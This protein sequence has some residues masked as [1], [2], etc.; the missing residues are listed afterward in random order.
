MARYRTLVSGERS[1]FNTSVRR[2]CSLTYWRRFRD[3]IFAI[4]NTFP[5]FKLVFRWLRP[6]AAREGFKL[7]AEDV[8]QSKVTFPAV[9]VL[10]VKCRFV[11]KP[12]ERIVA[13]F[14]SEHRHVHVTWPCGVARSFGSIC[15]HRKEQRAA[16]KDFQARLQR[17][18]TCPATI[19]RVRRSLVEQRPRVIKDKAPKNTTWLVLDHHPLYI[20]GRVSRATSRMF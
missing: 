3:D 12:R 18:F 2:W 1:L 15:L 8:S 4:T 17:F 6:R 14:L 20:T 9:D 5:R 13:P 10:V 11:T 19:S 16:E 7:L